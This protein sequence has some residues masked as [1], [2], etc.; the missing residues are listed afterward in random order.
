MNPNPLSPLLPPNHE[1]QFL[2]KDA[3]RQRQC[4]L[5]AAQTHVRDSAPIAALKW[6]TRNLVAIMIFVLMF[7]TLWWLV[8]INQSEV[9]AVAQPVPFEYN[10]DEVLLAAP[11]RE[12]LGDGPLSAESKIKSQDEPQKLLTAKLKSQSQ[13]KRQKLSTAKLKSKSQDKRP[14]L[15]TG[16]SQDERQNLLTAKL[17]AEPQNVPQE[18]LTDAQKLL[19]Q[20]GK[21]DA[22]TLYY[23]DCYL[24]GEQSWLGW[25]NDRKDVLRPPGAGGEPWTPE[26]HKDLHSEAN[27]VWFRDT[28]GCLCVGED[29][30]IGADMMCKDEWC[31]W[32]WVASGSRWSNVACIDLK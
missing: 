30:S 6:L 14:K 20:H 4:D 18:L 26:L 7:V 27:V 19:L 13:D 3:D 28:N 21:D 16:K 15:L 29:K 32:S 12:L 24:Y 9:F 11:L 23:K 17:K 25:G 10:V 2:N 22:Q 31:S 5:I 1:N 8:A